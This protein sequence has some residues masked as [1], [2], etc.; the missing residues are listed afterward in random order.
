MQTKIIE[1]VNSNGGE[2]KM[3]IRMRRVTSKVLTQGPYF[4]AIPDSGD[5]EPVYGTSLDTLFNYWNDKL[6]LK[7]SEIDFDENKSLW[8]TDAQ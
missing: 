7:S 2:L 6:V 5:Y 8:A 3:Y 1:S 4:E